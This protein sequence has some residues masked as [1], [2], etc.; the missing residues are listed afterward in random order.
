MVEV[1]VRVRAVGRVGLERR[2]SHGNARDRRYG[3]EARHSP[4]ATRRGSGAASS[5]TRISGARVVK[6]VEKGRFLRVRDPSIVTFLFQG[7]VLN[8]FMI[9]NLEK[10][11]RRPSSHSLF[12][13]LVCALPFCAGPP[14][15]LA[16]AA[17]SA[18]VSASP[19]HLPNV[20]HGATARA[21]GACSSRGKVSSRRN[22][23]AF[24]SRSHEPA[25]SGRRASGRREKLRQQS[26]ARAGA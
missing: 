9:K 7:F 14:R 4:S 11:E 19:A 23:L 24:S 13:V 15:A 5:Y 8:L 12:V 20:A 26:A 6:D 16:C 17:S 18:K 3:C 2:A 21:S 22:T 25:S 10:S 1:Q